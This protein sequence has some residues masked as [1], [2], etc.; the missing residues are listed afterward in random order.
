MK[1][2]E[3]LFSSQVRL[4]DEREMALDYFL[5]ETISETD[6][7]TPYFGVGITKKSGAITE[8]DEVCGVS[9]SKETAIGI[10]EKLYRNQVTPISLAEIV[11]ELVTLAEG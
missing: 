10:L 5:T 9:T 6:M 4:E 7:V 11:D 3:L 8:T 2:V 1:Q